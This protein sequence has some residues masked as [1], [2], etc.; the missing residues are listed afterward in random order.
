MH[1]INRRRRLSRQ[2]DELLVADPNA[3]AQL[4]ASSSKKLRQP[5]AARIGA[6]IDRYHQARENR[7]YLSKALAEQQIAPT[8]AFELLEV[9][10]DAGY[11]DPA[12]GRMLRKH[13]VET[14]RAAIRAL[15]EH[16]STDRFDYFRTIDAY[17]TAG[18]LSDDELA[19]LERLVDE[20]LNPDKAARRLFGEA[21]AAL[22][23]DEHERL[24]YRYLVEFEGYPDYADAAS[25]Y[26]AV[27]IDQLWKQLPVIRSA[28]LATLA[29][30]ELNTMLQAYLPLTSDI[31]D[32]VPVNRVYDDF[33]K[34]A[35]NFKPETD[36]AA[37]IT[38]RHVDTPVEV[39]NKDGDVEGR[40]RAERNAFVALGRV[41]R[42]RAVS[43]DNV[44]V[45]LRGYKF[46]YSRSWDVGAFKGTMY[47]TLGK[48][49]SFAHWKASE[50]GLVQSR[51]PSPVQVHQYKKAVQNMHDLLQQH[52]ED[53]SSK[54]RDSNPQQQ[55]R[56]TGSD[57]TQPG[58]ELN[59][60]EPRE[61]H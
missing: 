31:A 18:Y 27:R 47:E 54:Y 29:V 42:I 9:F 55:V 12:E 56:D 51:K 16:D 7:E 36:P 32:T 17:R 15:L 57:L 23:P 6:E 38:E 59:E 43:G 20:K 11:V 40:Y 53:H 49:S 2:L 35:G 24:L 45:E 39:L 28:R 13:I 44:I 10:D 22:E 60:A 1:F 3:A 8:A 14:H 46:E 26:L 52:R 48:H 58:R 4:Y 37:S 30:H 33:M 19:N 34:H 50:L 41:G 21:Q 5:D 61:T 25:L